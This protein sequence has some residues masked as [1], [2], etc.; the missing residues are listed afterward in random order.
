LKT[1]SYNKLL[2]DGI[3]QITEESGKLLVIETLDSDIYKKYF[4]DKLGEELEVYNQ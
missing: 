3:P 4:D 1:I 2:R